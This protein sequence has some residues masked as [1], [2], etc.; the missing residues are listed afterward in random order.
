MLSRSFMS[1]EYRTGLLAYSPMFHARLFMEHANY[2]DQSFQPIKTPW[3]SLPNT[4]T[5]TP[6]ES[7]EELYLDGN[8][9][10]DR[11]L[12]VQFCAN[13]PNALL[14]AAKFVAP[15]CDAVDLNLGCPCTS[16]AGR[17]WDSHSACGQEASTCQNPPPFPVDSASCL[18][19]A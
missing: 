18:R 1:P 4:S 11:P 8:P 14:E 17:S 13:D 12:F 7:S 19:D 10:I 9:E 2:R 5:A 15:Y 16:G 6:Q 3:A